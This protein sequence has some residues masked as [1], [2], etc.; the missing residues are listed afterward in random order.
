M[1]ERINQQASIP[2]V[3]I[4]RTEIIVNQALIDILIAKQIISEEELVNSIR[5]IKLEQEA[6]L[7]DSNKI[8]SLKR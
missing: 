6:M 8:V 5:K 3:E 7:K 2:A 4:L 1:A